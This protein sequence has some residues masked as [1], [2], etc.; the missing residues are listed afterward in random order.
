MVPMTSILF[1][2]SLLILFILKLSVYDT[3]FIYD[4]IDTILELWYNVIE[5]DGG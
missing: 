4:T 2:I 5:S 1:L 3:I